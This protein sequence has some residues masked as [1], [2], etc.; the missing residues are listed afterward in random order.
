MSA[1]AAK[2]RACLA[3]ERSSQFEGER[4]AARGRAEALCRKHGLD[5]ADFEESG[6]VKGAARE[7]P[8]ATNFRYVDIDSVLTPDLM[9][10]MRRAARH[11]EEEAFNAAWDEAAVRMRGSHA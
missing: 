4:T 9:E 5:I 7:R 6:P 8:R 11:G 1:I 3:L 10:A 2:V